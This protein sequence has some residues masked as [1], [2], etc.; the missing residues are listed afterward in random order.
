MALRFLGVMGFLCWAVGAMAQDVRPLIIAHRGASAVA[1]ENTAAAYRLAWE[2]N[3][4][5]AEVDV[6][7]TKDKKVVCLHDATLKRTTGVDRPIA[8]MTWDEVRVLDAGSWKG[9]RWTGEPVPLLEEVLALTPE[10]KGFFL[11]IK[12]SPGIVPY[13]AEILAASPRRKQ[14]TIIGFEFETMVEAHA[15][16]PDVPILWLIGSSKN[17][18]G[19]FQPI[20]PA[21]VRKALDAGFAGINVSWRGVTPEL[22]E[23]CREADTE[24]FVWTVNDP[25][26][27]RRLVAMGAAGITTDV[28]DVM[29]RE[30][31]GAE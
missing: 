29:L 17:D 10:G 4:D 6:Y 25:E 8:E 20:D 21:N 1:P 2:M 16:M 31:R 22:V 18:D 24:L 13:I 26:E 7:L 14:V 23:A 27:A 15:A 9:E 3:S 12:H 5:A 19:T 11:E 30:L 28:P